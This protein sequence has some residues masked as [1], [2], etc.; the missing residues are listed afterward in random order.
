MGCRVSRPT[1]CVWQ[2]HCRVNS[3]MSI[4]STGRLYTCAHVATQVS[5]PG[6]PVGGDQGRHAAVPSVTQQ[7]QAK[8]QAKRGN[9]SDYDATCGGKH[10]RSSARAGGDIPNVPAAALGVHACAVWG[11]GHRC[12]RVIQDSRPAL[13]LCG[14]HPQCSA[15][16][17]S[18]PQQAGGSPTGESLVVWTT[19]EEEET[20]ASHI[21]CC[22]C[23]T[24]SSTGQPYLVKDGVVGGTT[25][26]PASLTS[27]LKHSQTS[28]GTPAMAHHQPLVTP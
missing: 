4:S 26:H 8:L 13:L 11:P 22:V 18:R 7:K 21:E 10:E 16:A 27:R 2:Y 28:H 25:E 5:F 17:E 19:R 15:P 6:S 9:H 24:A 20:A 12:C 3:S 14:G 23:C 1:P